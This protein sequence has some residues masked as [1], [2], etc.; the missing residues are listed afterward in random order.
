MTRKIIILLSVCLTALAAFSPA[1]AEGIVFLVPIEG[2]IDGGLAAFV[3]RAVKEAQES[4]ADAVVFEVNTFGGRVDAAVVIRDAILNCPLKTIAF[5]NKRAISAGALISLATDQ[6]VMAGGSSIGAATAVDMQ[7]KKASEKVISYFRTEMRATAEKTGRPPKLAEAMV[8]EDVDIPDLSPKGKL[9]TLTTEEAIEHKMAEYTAETLDEVLA[10][11][12]LA[13]ATIVRIHVNWAEQIVR[14]LT[15]PMVSSLLITIGFLGLVFEVKTPGWG[16]GGTVGLVALAL[17]FGSHYLVYLAEW[18]EP[19]LFILGAVLLLIEILYIPGFGMVG[20]LGLVLMM[21]GIF[22]S[23]L[24]RLPSAQDIEQTFV[25][26]VLSFIATIAL[27]IL[28]LRTM[29]RTAFWN[30]LILQRVERVEEGFRSSP[31]EY[32]ELAGASGVAVTLLRPVGTGLFGKR[33]LNVVSDGEYIPKGT[34]IR[35]VR[36]EGNRIVVEQA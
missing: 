34:A 30:R 33:R 23:F 26:V 13:G 12:E 4:G 15:H 18:W 28:I 21:I 25:W 10:L 7:G 8:D 35:I 32:E 6:I 20:L 5:V 29:P 11:N 36:V 1:S 14:F 31:A 16:I 22:W 9:L 27:S 19:T 2:I 24:G 3:V 17:F